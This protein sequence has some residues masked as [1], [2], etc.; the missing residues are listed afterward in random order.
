MT[1]IEEAIGE[2]EKSDDL[3]IVVPGDFDIR[4]ITFLLN[5]RDY[6]AIIIDRAPVTSRETLMHAMYQNLR[7][8]GY[9]GFTWDSLKDIL[10][11]M[12]G[13]RGKGFIFAFS[14]FSLLPEEDRREFLE[15]IDDANEIRAPHEELERLRVL[16]LKA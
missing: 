12:D 14:D 4:D 11:G 3:L 5:E 2:I 10:A 9:F 13:V 8:P 6:H 16:A 1:P 15:V 7:F